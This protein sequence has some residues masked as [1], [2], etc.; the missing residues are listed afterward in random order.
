MK[1]RIWGARGSLPVALNHKQVRAKL[2]TALRGAIGRQLDDDAKIAAYLDEE[3]GF[4]V[5]GTY[6]GNS[7]CVEVEVWDQA[8]TREHVILDM[9]SGVR[10]LGGAKLARYGAGN[11]QTYHVFMS[12]LHWDHIM[13]FPFFTPAYI[14]GNRIIFYGCHEQLE[15]AMRRQQEA[16]S[17]PVSFDQLG[18]TI[19]FRCM[20]PG[21]ALEINGLRVTAKLQLHAGDSYGYR[22]EHGGRA[23]VYS[24]DSE[25]KLGDVEAG[26][27][28][29]EFFRDA[30]LVIFDAMYSLADS[31]SVKADWGHS[32]NVVGVELCQ[33]A[34]VRQLCLFHHEPIYDDAQIGRVLAE[35]RRYAQITG[36]APLKIV[37]AYDGMEIDL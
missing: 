17:F 27:A 3:L 1:A 18:A 14:P 31:I 25:H 35:T 8:N 10:Q 23:M 22:L 32:S 26:A 28:F 36:E 4:E 6:G 2:E 16:I 24:T 9:G 15:T 5:S 20:L 29:V 21:V 7:S 19:E 11:P 30:D 33:L 12:H 37:S 34:G 13:G